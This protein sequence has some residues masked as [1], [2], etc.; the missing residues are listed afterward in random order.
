MRVKQELIST[1]LLVADLIHRYPKRITAA[2]AAFLLCGASGAFAVASL[3]PA[4]PT[5]PLRLTSDALTLA[6]VQEQIA[7]LDAHHLTL[8]RDVQVRSADTAPR[9]LERA[10]VADPAA[11]R[12]LQRDKLSAQT[13]FS[14]GTTGRTVQVRSDD[15]QGLE[16][17]TMVW[18]DANDNARFHRL[19]VARD[20]NGGFT[21]R[22]ESDAMVPAQRLV[23]GV[24]GE[25][26]LTVTGRNDMPAAVEKQL[27]AIFSPTGSA[28]A[29]LKKGDRFAAVYEVWEAEDGEVLRTGRVLSAE[30]TRNGVTKSAIWFVPAGGEGHYYT[31]EGSRVH[32]TAI[33]VPLSGAL[34]VTS[35]FGLRLHPVLG[36]RL[37]HQGIDL[38]APRGTPVHAAADGTVQFA[39]VQHGYGNVVYLRHRNPPN[40]TT[41]YGHLSRIDVRVG[42]HVARGGLLGAVG[43]TGMTTGP[44]LH[45][46]IRVNGVPQNPAA[47]LA[48][49]RSNEGTILPQ[50]RGEFD[51]VADKMT[52]ELAVASQ[53]VPTDFD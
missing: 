13:L 29:S 17:L 53:L 50:A 6:P 4:V 42:E 7:L 43:S 19:V 49:A 20:A 9:L 8:Y 32:K 30:S 36:R 46:E 52:Q 23:S 35:G 26:V 1:G 11:A 21:S 3:A 47:A 28:G 10:G 27:H 39:G 16:R 22:I 41:I 37:E 25:G 33:K 48:A 45:F 34:R 44:H 31:P 18:P 15:E 24:V 40:E 12:F 2:V 14:R 51:A 38:A 5:E